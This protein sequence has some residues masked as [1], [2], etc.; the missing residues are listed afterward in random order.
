M[1]D[2]LE[3]ARLMR[4]RH[5]W[6]VYHLKHLARLTGGGT[7]AKENGAFWEGGDVP[8]I[9]PK[10]MKRRVIISAEDY[11]TE[12]AVDGSAT[13]F[14]DAGSPLMVV[15]S[16]ILR[17][18]LP[19][20]I[21]G[22]RLTLNQDMKAFN[23][24]SRLNPMFF[25]YWVEGQSSDLL[26][27]WRQFGATVESIDTG[28]LLNGRVALPDLPTQKA[29]A[30]FLDRETAC[31]DQL[32]EKKQRMVEVLGEKR[33][34]TITRS[35]C[36]D[37]RSEYHEGRDQG[38]SEGSGGVTDQLEQGRLMRCRRDWTVY[39]LK[40]LARLTGGGTPAKENSAFWE[41]G[42]VPWISPKDMKRRVITSAVD[43]ITEAAVDGSATSF[44]DAGSPLMVVRS[45]IL[46]HT[47]PVAI[48]GRRLTLNQDM[49]AFN[50][51]SRLNPMFFVYWVEGQSSDLLLEWR[52]F[53]ATVESIDTGRL[54]NGRLALP[55]LPTQKAIADFLD[56]ET[57]RI[58]A[59]ITKIRKTMDRLREF[60][61]AL[62]TAAVTGQINVSAWGK[63]GATGRRLDQI[64]EA[65]S[66]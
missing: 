64:E 21:A 63:Q 60:R 18:I 59:L 3:Q 42:D 43:Y 27:E 40:H 57:A 10:D 13:S 7:P 1:N 44:V 12:D 16:G 41:G 61:S 54:L 53:G 36:G 19:V 26:L 14:V 38:A 56:R 17:H 45:G 35:V 28:R 6:P 47:L 4:C 24:S 8:W 46:R 52:Q 34:A 33:T 37:H 15:R 48:A 9:S 23:L 11:I 50:L 30:D 49:K 65:T 29:I 55:D 62:I 2:Q 32:I 22:R 25:V 31:I 51:S 66:A 20:A 5:D 39:H 58:D